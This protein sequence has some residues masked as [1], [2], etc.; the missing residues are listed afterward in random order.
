M[1]AKKKTQ[2]EIV[3]AALRSR[4]AGLTDAELIQKTG[5][6]FADTIRAT[7]KRQK[8]VIA[9]GT[10]INKETNRTLKTWG[11]KA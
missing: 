2:V 5:I 1:A 7:L 6:P 8:K 11:V 3:L 10:K 4:K 9:V